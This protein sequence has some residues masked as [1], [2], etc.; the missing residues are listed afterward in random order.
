MVITIVV[1]VPLNDAI[2]AVDASGGV[3]EVSFVRS[4]FHEAR[5]IVCNVVRAILTTA[6]F[7]CLVLAQRARDRFLGTRRRNA[8]SCDEGTPAPFS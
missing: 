3:R 7:I 2:N 1:Y 4:A 6:A 8:R 5:W